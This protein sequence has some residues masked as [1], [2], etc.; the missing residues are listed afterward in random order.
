MNRTYNTNQVNNQYNV[1]PGKQY[2]WA[3]IFIDRTN[4]NNVWASVYVTEYRRTKK[5]S[6]TEIVEFKSYDEM[7]SYLRSHFD[8]Y[9]LDHP[10]SLLD[11]KLYFR[12]VDYAYV[13][14]YK[15]DSDPSDNHLEIG[16]IEYNNYGSKPSTI[17][18]EPRYESMILKYLR[19]NRN[20]P[21]NMPLGENIYR[22][23]DVNKQIRQNYTPQQRLTRSEIR[24][25][26]ERNSF[27]M[28]EAKVKNHTIRNLVIFSSL[29]LLLAT[30]GIRLHHRRIDTSNGIALDRISD[31]GDFG[32]LWDKVGIEENIIKLV[33]MNYGDVSESNVDDVISYFEKLEKSNYDHNTSFNRILLSE[34]KYD[35]T[36]G[37]TAYSEEE[38]IRKLLDKLDSLYYGSFNR[39]NMDNDNLE[40]DR[41]GAIN[42][43]N[44]ALPCILMNNG[45]YSTTRY[46]SVP[47]YLDTNNSSYPSAEVINLYAKLPPIIQ[48]TQSIR[49]RE[50][51]SHINEGVKDPKRQYEFK[52][53]HYVTGKKD[54]YSIR[55]VVNEALKSDIDQMKNAINH[56]KN[57]DQRTTGKK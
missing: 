26:R 41:E 46:S 15:F 18:L 33:N 14:R 51:L 39:P 16:L 36:R 35:V 9:E 43:L 8:C 4:P 20:I 10:V 25:E 24:K 11:K 48:T 57:Q 23:I 3:S 7:I 55:G 32:L 40:L 47:R 56:A 13:N 49:V 12:Y 44:Y 1:R 5:V 31:I 30:E 27:P 42:Y 50:M 37:Y 2:N 29:F 52:F 22:V 6:K 21:M 54:A 45:L 34:Y 19:L 38:N 28:P 53:P 17:E